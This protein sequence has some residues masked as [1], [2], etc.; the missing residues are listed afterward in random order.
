MADN[1][2]EL[3][4]AMMVALQGVKVLETPR[5]SREVIVNC[6]RDHTAMLKTSR[7]EITMMAGVVKQLSAEATDN[8]RVLQNIQDDAKKMRQDI[9][10]LFRLT[11][12]FRIEMDELGQKI[13]E[14]MALKKVVKEQGD[15]IAD[16]NERHEAHKVEMADYIA[17]TG[18][19]IQALD[20]KCN[21]TQ[22]QLKELREYVD[23]FGDNLILNSNQ[24]IV[25]S[26]AGYSTRPLSL[27][28]ILK[29]TNALNHDVDQ[30]LT[31]QGK[32][33][34]ENTANISRKADD[35]IVFNVDTLE[36]KVKAIEAHLKREEE[37]GV[38]AIRRSCDQLMEAV[39]SIQFQLMDKVGQDAV[40]S[41]VHKKYE[42]IVQYLQDALSSSAE[43]ENNFKQ[44]ADDLTNLVAKLNTI[45]ADRSEVNAL[46]EMMVKTEALL[47]KSGAK[48][49]ANVYTRKEIEALLELKLDKAD[50]EQQVQ[51]VTKG[52][53]KKKLLGSM[54]HGG[55]PGMLG[56]NTGGVNGGGGGANGQPAVDEALGF[57]IGAATSP[58]GLPV[59]TQASRDAAMWKGLADVMKDESE[60]AMMRAAAQTRATSVSNASSNDFSAY[61][62]TKKANIGKPAMSMSLPNS[63][64][65]GA[66][67]M[68]SEGGRPGGDHQSF[69][70]ADNRPESPYATAQQRRI[71]QSNSVSTIGSE[72]YQQ[73]Y[74]HVPPEF[75]GPAAAEG[76][77][78]SFI[79][80]SH[81][82]SGFNMRGHPHTTTHSQKGQT[83]KPL[84]DNSSQ[85]QDIEGSGLMVKGAD[86][87]FYYAS[88]DDAEAPPQR[89]TGSVPPNVVKVQPKQQS[90]N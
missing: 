58:L 45:K 16:L 89:S 60:A 2:K 8:R 50:F 41:I 22:F 86:N 27:L 82:G 4:T 26:S 78:L 54:I 38:S 83:L 31:E 84:V 73:F 12:D 47:A 46:Q 33:I 66:F 88:K 32:Q 1:E 36:T 39:D 10:S 35:S 59:S 5:V 20:T 75:E 70:S 81:A 77:D 3:F 61:I 51:Q 21:D 6:L 9:D 19:I 42:D 67:R 17:K 43:D 18:S 30:R 62:K 65:P 11:A 15:Y 29:Q 48:P 28:E 52:G 64:N 14:L 68:P 49:G 23:R 24:I 57:G 13:A 71:V 40:D 44:K 85:V 72:V 34:T 63:S 90:T 56:S 87:H 76:T 7:T 25:E 80:G 53:K 37:Q 55:V 79:G 74:P 69:S